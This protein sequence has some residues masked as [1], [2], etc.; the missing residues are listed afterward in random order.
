MVPGVNQSTVPA[1]SRVASN[2]DAVSVCTTPCPPVTTYPSEHA[3]CMW[4]V[5]PHLPS[6]AGQSYTDRCEIAT[7]P[8]SPFSY[9]V[10]LRREPC[11]KNADHRTCLGVN[12]WQDQ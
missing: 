12:D 4:G 5:P 11:Q 7:P 2:P 6:S 8:G 3:R 10:M 9:A 1:W